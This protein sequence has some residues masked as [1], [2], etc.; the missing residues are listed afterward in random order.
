MEQSAP[1]QIAMDQRL[2]QQQKSQCCNGCDWW[3]CYCSFF[4]NV[5]K[6]CDFIGDCCCSGDCCNGECNCY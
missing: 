5:G 6:C 1:A 2:L 3:M 4:D